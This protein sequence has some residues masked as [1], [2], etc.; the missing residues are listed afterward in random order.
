MNPKCSIQKSNLFKVAS[1]S[2]YLSDEEYVIPNNV[3]SKYKSIFDRTVSTYKT[4]PINIEL[5][6]YA[7]PYHS[8]SHPV[9]RA[10]E[11]VFKKYVDS[12]CQLGVLLKSK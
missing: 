4:K 8:R 3:L 5:K 10:H 11:S 9:P 7:K 2:K 12:I 6:P 1:E